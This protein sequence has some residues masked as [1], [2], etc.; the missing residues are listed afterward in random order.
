METCGEHSNPVECDASCREQ[1]Y[2]CEESCE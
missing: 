1:A 2:E